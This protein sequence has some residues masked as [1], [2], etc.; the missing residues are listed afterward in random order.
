CRVRRSR[1]SE[2]EPIAWMLPDLCRHPGYRSRSDSRPPQSRTSL[3][4]DV[5]Q[6]RSRRGS[7][8]S[9]MVALDVARLD[10]NGSPA[11]RHGKGLVLMIAKSVVL[12]EGVV[13]HHPDLVNLYGCRL[14]AGS[15]V[16][17]FVEIQRG[18]VI[19]RNCK[20]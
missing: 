1:D 16:G 14:G 13:I 3:L 10:I 19:G 7:S 6:A 11:R 12:E 17:T 4:C 2:A 5:G 18:A 15:R 9:R 8:R 20:I